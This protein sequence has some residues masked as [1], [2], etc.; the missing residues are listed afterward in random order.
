MG[1]N[2]QMPM[3]P[4]SLGRRLSLARTQRRLTQSQL[5][6]AADM[7]Q[8]DISKI[9]LGLIQQTTGIARLAR[10]LQVPASWLELGEGDE[11][12]WQ[13]HHPQR[14]PQRTTAEPAISGILKENDSLHLYQSVTQRGPIV[15]LRT[16]TWEQLVS[17]DFKEP[18]QLRIEGDALLPEYPAGTTGVFSPGA[19]CRPGKPVLIQDGDGLFHLRIYQ[20]GA[21]NRWRGISHQP[22]YDPLSNDADGVQLVAPMTGHLWD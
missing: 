10:V 4:N 22:G 3:P 1:L 11:P 9:E 7:R 16:V 15:R 19:S 8:P 21:G 14:V 17:E 6:L 12:D 13:T 5:A 20:T 18:F 2:P